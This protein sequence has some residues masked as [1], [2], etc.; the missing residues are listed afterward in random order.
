MDIVSYSAQISDPSGQRVHPLHTF[1]SPLCHR[2][3]PY[4]PTLREAPRWLLSKRLAGHAT[5]LTW[6][7][8]KEL[9]SGADQ[10]TV[11]ERGALR[12]FFCE[13]EGLELH[14]VMCAMGVTPRRM[15][16]LF[17]DLGV[18]QWQAVL[19][20]NQFSSHP[21]T[22]ATKYWDSVCL[23]ALRFDENGRLL[24]RDTITVK[25]VQEVDRAIIERGL[26]K[27]PKR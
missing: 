8:A 20:I 10:G 3:F 6:E 2:V 5:K 27:P 21:P 25:S 16:E 19:W 13:L 15:A 24:P 7:R 18:G 11:D 9:V 17:I 26:G 14:S 22:S 1:D 23:G 4:V 12:S